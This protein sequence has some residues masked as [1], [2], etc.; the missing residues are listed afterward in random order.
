MSC[1]WRSRS[2]SWVRVGAVSVPF[3]ADTRSLDGALDACLHR[4]CG[5]RYKNGR[6]GYR[7]CRRPAASAA[8]IVART[9][10]GHPSLLPLGARGYDVLSHPDWDVG[11]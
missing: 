6:D 9:A 4:T 5:T 1:S 10:S 8:R 3:F 2:F 11:P 7:A